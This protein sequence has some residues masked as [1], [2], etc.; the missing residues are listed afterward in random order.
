MN[1]NVTI[2]PTM[3]NE[4]PVNT[5]NVKGTASLTTGTSWINVSDKRLKDVQGPYTPGLDAVLSLN[6]I[7]FRYKENNPLGLPSDKEIVG[8]IAQDVEAYIPE[9]VLKRDDGYLELNVD[10]IHWA[11]INA[12]KELHH[13]VE[14]LKA[15]NKR[16]RRKIS[17]PVELEK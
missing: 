1:G 16:L 13:E 6:P 14:I 3:W 17:K 4:H 10:P 9:A 15:E 7:K 12:I 5:F 2:G 8:V 11:T